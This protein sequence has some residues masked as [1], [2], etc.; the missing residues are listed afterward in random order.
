MPRG[1]YALA[2]SAE[3]ARRAL[4][5]ASCPANK[6]WRSGCPGCSSNVSALLIQ[7]RGLRR[8]PYDDMLYACNFG[9]WG[10]ESAVH[11]S[12]AELPL[13]D[14]QKDELPVRCWRKVL[15]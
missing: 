14:R 3:V 10:N 9:G 4:I 2:A 8:T 7:V 1:G 15:A 6:P 11:L 13:T 5:C 12:A